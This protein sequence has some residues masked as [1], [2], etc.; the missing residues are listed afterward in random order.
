MGERAKGLPKISLTQP[1][2]EPSDLLWETV[3]S[4]SPTLH[5]TA[6]DGQMRNGFPLGAMSKFTTSTLPPPTVGAKELQ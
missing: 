5:H 4:D 6:E 3:N 1:C 2:R